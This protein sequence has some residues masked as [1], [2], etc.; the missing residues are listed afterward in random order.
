MKDTTLVGVGRSHL[1]VKAITR[2]GIPDDLEETE[3]QTYQTVLVEADDE[4][5]AIK[6]RDTPVHFSATVSLQMEVDDPRA[7]HVGDEIIIEVY[8]KEEDHE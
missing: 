2:I 1:T 7:F 5:M 6:D 4:R 3:Y 8:S